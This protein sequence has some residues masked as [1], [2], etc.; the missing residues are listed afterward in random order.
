MQIAVGTEIPLAKPPVDPSKPDGIRPPTQQYYEAMFSRIDA[1]YPIDFYWFWTPEGWEW[2]RTALNSS[3]VVDA[4]ADLE[5]AS[6]A[7]KVVKP[8]FKLATCGWVLGPV[9]NRALLDQL[10]PEYAALASIEQDLGQLGPDPSYKAI[11][12]RDSWVIP[13]M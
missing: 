8:S 11:S 13:W 6:A 5:A 3:L 9:G 2:S 1:A 4:L 7:Y 12:R 10:G